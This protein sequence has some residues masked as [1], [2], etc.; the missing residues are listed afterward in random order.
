M[1]HLQ[2]CTHLC[3]L[4]QF[5][6]TLSAKLGAPSFA[7]NNKH[8]AMG[9]AVAA[10]SV[11]AHPYA[12]SPAQYQGPAW[13]AG[14]GAR[15]RSG[16]C[17]SASMLSWCTTTP[18]CVRLSGS[19]RPSLCTHLPLSALAWTGLQFDT[20]A[21]HNEQT[22]PSCTAEHRLNLGNAA[23]TAG[24]IF[25]GGTGLCVCQMSTTSLLYWP[26]SPLSRRPTVR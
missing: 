7:L 11:K 13:S 26:S 24:W 12:G 25:G 14:T 3:G 5:S 20:T 4:L 2:T 10:R 19:M 9:K 6:G 21:S 23:G 22:L 18:S 15:A 1:T 8:F 17:S 16:R